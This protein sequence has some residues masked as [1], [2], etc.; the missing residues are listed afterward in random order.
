MSSACGC[1]VLR[2]IPADGTLV[3]GSNTL[4]VDVDILQMLLWQLPD[5]TRCAL[6]VL[7][8]ANGQ[9]AAAV[10]GL[11]QLCRRT[12]G[13]CESAM[14]TA[15]IDAVNLTEPQH[16]QVRICTTDCIRR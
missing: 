14:H 12:T 6:S 13:C 3:L 5:T 1:I 10:V 11:R 9:A 8:T 4:C 15:A 16:P 2:I 7:I